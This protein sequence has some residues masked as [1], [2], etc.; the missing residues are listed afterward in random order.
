M[1]AQGR[2]GERTSTAP[3]ELID[4]SAMT[5]GQASTM[6]SRSRA[7]FL[8]AFLVGSALASCSD[9]QAGTSHVAVATIADSPLA[10]YQKELLDLAFDTA[11][12]FPTVPHVKNRARAQ[13]EVVQACFELDQPQRARLAVWQ[14][15]LHLH[16]KRREHPPESH[17]RRLP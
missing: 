8:S 4:R 17:G 1:K 6:N 16:R 9:A 11:S 5:P 3:L 12:T 10:E 2:R 14:R 13:G 15:H 7:L